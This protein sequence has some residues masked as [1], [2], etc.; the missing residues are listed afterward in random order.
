MVSTSQATGT[1]GARS[2]A[3]AGVVPSVRYPFQT[4]HHHLERKKKKG[5]RG[6]GW[7]RRFYIQT[8]QGVFVTCLSRDDL[9]GCRLAIVVVDMVVG[10]ILLVLTQDIL[11]GHSGDDRQTSWWSLGNGRVAPVQ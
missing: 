5:V 4:E 9:T 8:I 11:A 6:T 1:C 3:F 10:F 2:F 7:P